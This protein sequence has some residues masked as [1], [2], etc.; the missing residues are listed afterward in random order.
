M[1]LHP[2]PRHHRQ[3]QRRHCDIYIFQRSEWQSMYC[4]VGLEWLNWKYVDYEPDTHLPLPFPLLRVCLRSLLFINCGNKK[5]TSSISRA[6]KSIWIECRHFSTEENRLPVH[7]KW[8]VEKV[9]GKDGYRGYEMV[10]DLWWNG[11]IMYFDLNTF[12]SKEVDWTG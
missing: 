6:E 5:T 3:R 7:L 1:I 4:C 12:Y 8:G 9:W 2:R 11:K 10:W